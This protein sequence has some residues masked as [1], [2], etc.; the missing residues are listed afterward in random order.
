[1]GKLTKY[2]Q[3]YWCVVNQ[4][5]GQAEQRGQKR[6]VCISASNS[7]SNKLS[8]IPFNLIHVLVQ[9]LKANTHIYMGNQATHTAIKTDKAHEAVFFFVWSGWCNKQ[10]VIKTEV[11]QQR[12]LVTLVCWSLYRTYSLNLTYAFAFPLF[13]NGCLSCPVVCVFIFICM[14]G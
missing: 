7:F 4:L 5:M 6:V 10:T 12:Y 14:C 3:C 1:M 13:L 8:F 11:Q 9:F 2:A